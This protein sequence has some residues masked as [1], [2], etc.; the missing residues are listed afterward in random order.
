M[1]KPIASLLAA[2]ALAVFSGACKQKPASSPQPQAQP[3][4]PTLPA[5]PPPRPGCESLEERCQA[6]PETELDVPASRARFRPPAS[7][8]Y[9][10]ESAA[11]VAVAP[12]GNAVLAFAPA[13]S[14]DAEAMAVTLEQLFTRLKITGVQPAY[15][16][17]RFQKPDSTLPAEGGELRLW[18]L[19][20]KPVAPQLDGK[21][22]SLLVIHTVLGGQPLIGAGFVVKPQAESQAA[23]IM[24]AVQSLR[25]A[26][27]P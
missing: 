16:K 8:T 10:K 4:D 11:A 14:A 9:A 25:A 21:N 18:E 15:I 13:T 6:L 19:E 23:P 20:K 12:D 2:G 7:W 3:N 1:N 27:A 26:S 24:A 22:G 17:G 5:P